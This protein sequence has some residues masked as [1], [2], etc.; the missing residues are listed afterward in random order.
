M[1]TTHLPVSVLKRDGRV[2]SF[3]PEKITNAIAKA[4][5]ATNEFS[6][7]TAQQLTEEVLSRLPLQETPI[8][9]EEIQDVVED[10]LLSSP[11]KKT[12]KAYIIYRDQHAKMR[13][14]A[15]Q[16]GIDIVET[17]E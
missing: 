13:E 5:Q 14:I 1:F 16:R 11:Y 15:R 4:G 7:S 10:V 12:A 6:L 8:H 17:G 3:N 9:V 2:V